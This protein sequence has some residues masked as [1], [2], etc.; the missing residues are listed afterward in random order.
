[1]NFSEVV[2]STRE[3]KTLQKSNV[4]LIFCSLKPLGSP[5]GPTAHLPAG[6]AVAAAAPVL[7][8]VVMA[9]TW[10]SWDGA[11]PAPSAGQGWRHCCW[12][13][14]SLDLET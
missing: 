12:Q 6:S 3:E 7:A 4:E 11:P 14:A 2:L 13:G 9:E 5:L 1:M 10:G 8:A